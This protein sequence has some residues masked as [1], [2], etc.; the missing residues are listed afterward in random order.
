V[1]VLAE[2]PVRPEIR[3]ESEDA[4]RANKWRT[5]IEPI[6]AIE[7]IMWGPKGPEAFF[8]TAC[9]KKAIRRPYLSVLSL[10]SRIPMPS[11]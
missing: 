8:S 2:M 6:V 3:G 10:W 4:L 5:V 1:H 11:G 9:P 7:Q